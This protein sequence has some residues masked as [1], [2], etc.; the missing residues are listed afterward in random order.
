M[1]DLESNEALSLLERAYRRQRLFAGAVCL[2]VDGE[3]AVRSVVGADTGSLFEIG[4]ITKMLTGISAITADS[5]GSLSLDAR[6]ED[7]VPGLRFD[8]RRG[9][10][11]SVRHLLTHTSGLPSAGRDWGPSDQEALLRVATEDVAHHRLHANPGTIACYSSTAIALVGSA[12][13]E[14]KGVPFPQLLANETLRPGGM[15]AACY[16]TQVDPSDMSWP[17]ALVSGA[18]QPEPRQADNPAGYPSGFL[19]ASLD[20]LTHMALTLLDGELGP[21]LLEAMVSTT[22]SRWMDHVQSPWSRISANYGLGSLTGL[23]NGQTVIR[24]GGMGLTS[25]CSFDLFPES[26]SAAVLLT[27]GSDEPT[28]LELFK[29]CYR[30]IAGEEAPPSDDQRELLTSKKEKCVS[31]TFLNVNDGRQVTIRSDGETMWIEANDGWAPLR[32][33]GPGKWLS[34]D[35]A[36]GTPIGIP[37][38]EP[39]V[40]HIMVWGDLFQRIEIPDEF[41]PPNGKVQGDYRDSFWDDP[42]LRMAITGND[43]AIV[44]ESQG[45]E[46]DAHWIATNRLVSDHGL[47]EPDGTDTGFIL[48]NATK[49]TRV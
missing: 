38:T 3:V 13:Q 29:S 31:G 32:A 30:E 17:H 2:I 44:V 26:R 43:D 6:I 27:N 48:G 8:D 46:S 16:P 7:V 15:E 1:P 45:H 12:L 14:A 11:V 42:A 47:I 35:P 33:V 18:W 41:N 24:H 23:W 20:D 28:F 40:T 36:P 34:A 21:G 5:E 4:S 9:A 39:E 25:N 49:Y 19:L 22:A 10:S 37:V